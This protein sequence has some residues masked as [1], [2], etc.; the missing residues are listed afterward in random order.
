MSKATDTPAARLPVLLRRADQ[1]VVGVLVLGALV[2]MA[3]Y[4]TLQGGQRG[5][6]IEIDRAQPLQ[7]RFLVNINEADWPELSQL[8]DVGEVL[9]RRI[10]DSRDKQGPYLDHEELLRVNGIGP[11][12]L[13]RIRPYLL[14]VPGQQDVAA[15]VNMNENTL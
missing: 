14:P 1:V 7:Y 12:T 11:L 8:P 10:V 3:V 4:W 2:S 5:E 15:E 9:A 6:L 13:E